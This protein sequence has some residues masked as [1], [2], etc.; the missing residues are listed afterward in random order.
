MSA[1]TPE[2]EL[3]GDTPW[4]YLLS[5]VFHL[6]PDKV[7]E[8]Y[9]LL[10]DRIGSKAE[11]IL[12]YARKLQA[13]PYVERITEFEAMIQEITKASAS[14]KEELLESISTLVH[15][16]Q[17]VELCEYLL[18]EAI[19]I[20]IKPF[21]PNL[22][23]QPQIA[24]DFQT[25]LT[26]LVIETQDEHTTSVLERYQMGAS[27]WPAI[28]EQA[29]QIDSDA[30][31]AALNRCRCTPFFVRY[32]IFSGCCQALQLPDGTIPAKSFFLLK[33]LAYVLDCLPFKPESGWEPKPIAL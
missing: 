29:E 10:E 25:L 28:T 23:T 8:Q 2:A 14:Q 9:V 24:P 16:D 20:R 31:N 19:T 33:C 3:N 5:F 7:K 27:E 32:K 1:I 21:F 15:S 12:A 13:M 26:A 18:Q 6:D 11:G 4:N 17:Q 22:Y 30:V